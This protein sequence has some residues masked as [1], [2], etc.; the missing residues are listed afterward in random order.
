MKACHNDAMQYSSDIVLSAISSIV[1]VGEAREQVGRGSGNIVSDNIQ[2]GWVSDRGWE[3][4]WFRTQQL[5]ND[6]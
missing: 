2:W 6:A 5:L 1:C 4:D 3:S